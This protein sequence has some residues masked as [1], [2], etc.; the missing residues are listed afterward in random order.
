MSYEKHTFCSDIAE[1]AVNSLIEEV[2]L[3]PKPGLVDQAN[4]G[5]HNDLTIQLMRKSAESLRDTFEEIAYTSIDQKPSQYIR[6][7]IANIGR[8]GE[9]K[10]FHETN[11]INTHKGAIWSIGLLV[12]AYSMGKGLY[13][14]KE[15]VFKAGD[16]ARFPD[17][18]YENTTTNGGRVMAKYGVGGARGEAEQG[19]PHIV[20]YSL[21]ILK[22]M[23]ADGIAEKEAQL[24]ALLSLISQL[25]DTC[26]LHRGGVQALSYAK[27]QANTFL[28]AGHLGRLTTLDKEFTKRNI[29]PGGSADLLAV[30][31]F[32]D[33][34]QAVTTL[35]RSHR[36]Y[37]HNH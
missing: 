30:T 5:A 37:E 16:I 20:N 24:Y 7:T 25:D 10:M 15:I 22:Q 29:S 34:T 6:E 35:K 32:L 14:I 13:T 9:K 28:K 11:G 12:S 31:L 1:I 2:E 36:Q 23:R 18:F 19:F 26:I 27:E 21:P 8:R 17:R 4:T 33:K 3:T